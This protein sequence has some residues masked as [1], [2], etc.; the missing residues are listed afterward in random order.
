[1][2]EALLQASATRVT[3]AG[4]SIGAYAASP[5][6]GPAHAIAEPQ[7]PSGLSDAHPNDRGLEREPDVLLLERFS[8][9]ASVR[10]L[11]ASDP[12]TG[13]NLGLIGRADDAGFAPIDGPALRVRILKNTNQALN[14]Q[15]KLAPLNGGIEPDEAYFRYH[16]RL[17]DD[18]DP[19][20]DGGKLPGFAGTY[21]RG[22]WGMRHSD[23]S[24]GWS[25]RGAFM[26]LLP[27]MASLPWRGIGTYAY[28]ANLNDLSGVVWGWNRGSS[29]LIPKNRWVAVEQF[30]RMNT[31]GVDDGALKVWIDGRLA[32]EKTDIRWRTTPDLHIES[33]W[34][35]VYH[36]G[37]S[38]PDRDL[39]LYI[40][41]LVIA[42]RPIGPGR[43]EGR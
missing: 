29:G 15:I 17:G 30:L 3:G 42:R 10:K 35:N 31:P 14:D 16:L 40:D 32:F 27:D 21:G 43:F 36:G 39:T 37:V 26:Q 7:R 2:V 4:A 6:A 24:N 20:V 22:G 33:V 12:A 41:N 8:D 11:V 23:G 34:L 5:P 13:K 25:A 28:T 9:D 1:V 18:W 38:K 19:T